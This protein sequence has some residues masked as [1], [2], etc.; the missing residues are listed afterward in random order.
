MKLDHILHHSQK[1]TQNGLKTNVRLETIELLE[2]NI[3]I[4]LLDFGLGNDFFGFDT[5]YK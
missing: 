4:K 1:L 3:G 2:E 5:K